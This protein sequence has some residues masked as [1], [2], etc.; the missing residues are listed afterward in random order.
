MSVLVIGGDK[1]KNIFEV[2]KDFGAISITH[3]D[4]RKK[5]SV[6]KKDIPKN[7][8][9]VV[10]LTSYLNHNAMKYF[11][12]QA[13]KRALPFVCVKSNAICVYSE[14]EKIMKNNLCENCIENNICPLYK[15]SK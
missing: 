6:T 4:A 8:D 5:T 13:K 7:I 11:K 9:I 10:M 15:G 12:I 3:W 2:L 14:F 1:V